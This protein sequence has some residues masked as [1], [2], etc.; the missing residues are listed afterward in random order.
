MS[1]FV[2]SLPRIFHS[3]VIVLTLTCAFT[4]PGQ[5]AKPSEKQSTPAATEKNPA[6]IELLETKYRFEINGDSRKEVHTRVRINNELGVR[7]FARLNFDFNRS[8]Q[9]VEIPLVRITHA[10]GGVADILPSAITDNPN[11]TVVDFPAYHDVRVKSVRI[12]GLQP[13]DLLEYRVITT[14]THHPLAPDFWLDHTFDRSGVVSQEIFEIDVPAARN[15]SIRVNP[16]IP[17]KSTVK[18]GSDANARIVYAWDL[19][20][21]NSQ[22]TVSDAKVEAQEADVLLSTGD[23]RM[24]SIR[25]SEKLI[26]GT[27]PLESIH[28]YEEQQRE[29]VRRGQVD[30]G[31]VAKAEVLTRDAKTNRAKFRA[32]YDFVSQK[33]TTVDLPLGATGFSIRSANEI[34]KSG[35]ATPEDKYVVFA[36]LSTAV[37]LGAE[38][39]LTG[40]CDSTAPAQPIMFKHLII[41]AYDG[42][43][44]IW[45]DPTLEVA[46]FGVIPA[47]SGSCAFILN[48]QFFEMNSIGHEWQPLSHELPFPS[49]QTVSV[50]AHL[51]EAATLDAKVRYQLRGDNELLLRVAF[52]KTP[53]DKWKEIAQLLAISDGFRGEIKNVTASD[54]YATEKP[55]E[56]EYQI[57]QPKFVDWSKKTVRVPALLPSPSLPDATPTRASAGDADK[58][59]KKKI[60]NLGTPL[61][62]E[63]TSTVQLPPGTTALAPT[64]TSVERD[65]ATFSSKYSVSKSDSPAGQT[66]ITATRKLRFLRKEIPAERAPDFNAFLHAVQSDQLQLFTLQPAVKT[67]EAP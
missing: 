49:A 11:P 59:V 16:V 30:P 63:L 24:L 36:A 41:S 64:G 54:P 29:S 5:Q 1:R 22:Q 10:S 37:K 7:Q 18:S 44:A 40:F 48:W 56:V 39:A 17:A 26:P 66:T 57:E 14:T 13:E 33:I 47:S 34:L 25:L 51:T 28:T 31:I 45:A 38:A 62:I 42:T 23:W 27:T 15:P 9:S 46:P 12:L 53:K 32:L 65:Y 19:V 21:K 43:K 60:I 4:S 55:F 20:A 67:K 3:L 6:Q 50:D 58:T 52:N 8:F 35:Y 61:D 2:G